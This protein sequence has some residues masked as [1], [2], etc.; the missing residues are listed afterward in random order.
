MSTVAILA[1]RRGPRNTIP[2]DATLE[3]EKAIVLYGQRPLTISTLELLVQR[4]NVNG[5]GIN[6]SESQPA[7][8]VVISN[9]DL[10]GMFLQACNGMA[11][12]HG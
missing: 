3:G 6:P 12:V 1:A 7:L 9:Y 8:G 5:V 4:Q 11:H 10:V 2:A